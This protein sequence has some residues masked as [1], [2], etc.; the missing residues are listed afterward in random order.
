MV[1]R[2]E[3]WLGPSGW[4]GVLRIED[5]ITAISPT[6]GLV[7]PI[8]RALTGLSPVD[9]VSPD[10]VRP[11][12]PNIAE[13]LG[14]ATLFY[15]GERFGGAPPDT[16]VDIVPPADIGGLLDG[17]DQGELDESGLGH[18]TSSVSILRDEQ[19]EPIAGCGYRLWPGQVAHLS[20]LTRAEHRG[21][22]FAKAVGI[23]ASTRALAEGLLPQWRARTAPSQ[24]VARA[25]GF[26]PLGAQLSL[27]PRRPIGSDL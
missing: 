22:G 3:S 2:R 8:T 19:G 9:A 10:R 12:L 27:R 1:T 5:C 17:V 24:A 26:E 7:E 13:T 18:V 11:R 21:T 4:I 14:P 16:A 20:V 6:P 15:P 25:I 23:H